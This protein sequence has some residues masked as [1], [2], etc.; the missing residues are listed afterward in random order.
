MRATDNIAEWIKIGSLD[1]LSFV[2]RDVICYSSGCFINFLNIYT[3]EE[4]K[5]AC[6][7]HHL[8]GD[9]VRIVRGHRSLYTFAYAEN[10]GDAAIYVKNYPGFEA[11]AKFT[12]D[13]PP[14]GYS[15]MSFSESSIL[16]TVGDIPDFTISVYNWRTN[17]KL[18][19]FKN[20]LTLENQIVRCNWTKPI[21][22]TQLMAVI[23]TKKVKMPNKKD[24]KPFS[25]LV[26]T[27]EGGMFVVD[28]KG[29]V[30]MLNDEVSLDVVIEEDLE[31]DIIPSLCNYKGGIVVNGPNNEIR[32]Y[33]KAGEWVC[34]WTIPL[35]VSIKNMYGNRAEY[36]IGITNNDKI[37][38]IS[39]TNNEITYLKESESNFNDICLIY[40]TGEHVVALRGNKDL[41]VYETATG[42]MVSNLQLKGKALAIAE[43]PEFPYV[44]VGYSNG[45]LELI[46]A[47]K[48]A[49]L[50]L[51]ASFNLTSNPIS[52]L[53][54]F[55]QGRV[56]VTGYLDVGEFFLIEGLPGTEMKVIT[57]IYANK[58]IVDYML[59]ASKHCYRLFLLPVTTKYMAS[60]KIIRYC[61][62]DTGNIN[63]KEYTMEDDN[64][65]YY[66][67]IPLTDSNRDRNFYMLPYKARSIHVLETKRG[68]PLARLVQEIK[69]GHLL[70]RFNFRMTKLHALTWG[71]DGFIIA[72]DSKFEQN[73]GMAIAHH[74]YQGG[75]KKAYVD[76]L[77]KYIVSLGVEG[78]MVCTSIVANKIDEGLKNKLYELKDSVKYAVMFKRPTIGFKPEKRFHGKTWL[79]VQRALN[80]EKEEEIC[81]EEKDD[82]KKE[83]K[84]IKSILKHLVT[85]NIEG[86]DNERLD[87]LEF[88]LD[89][90]LYNNKRD[91]NKSDCKNAETYLK[92]LI[93]AQDEVS[94]HLMKNYWEPMDIR[95]KKAC[96]IFSKSEIGN[97]VLLPT[98]QEQLRRTVWIAEQRKVE[99][100]LSKDT[101]EPWM[102]V[103][104]E[105]LLEQFQQ[106]PKIE[107]EDYGKLELQQKSIVMERMS[108]I[109]EDT[110]IA[111][112]GTIAQLYIDRSLGH[113]KQ[114]Q[115]VSY[116]QCDI[117]QRITEIDA[118]KLKKYFNAIFE[119]LMNQK[120]REMSLVTERNARLRVIIS[121]MNYFSEKKI[122]MDIIDPEWDD[123]EDPERITKVFDN[124]LTITPYISPSE[125]AILDAKAAEE[126]RI[127]LALLADD[128]RERALM[129][130]MNGVLEV[131]WEDELKKDV[132]I[133][134]CMLEKEPEKYNEEDLRAIRDYEEKVIFLN[135]ERERYKNLLDVEFTKLTTMSRDSIRKFNQKVKDT[136]EIKMHIDSA[137]NQDNLRINRIRWHEFTRCLHH[138]KEHEI[139]EKIVQ[140]E[141]SIRKIPKLMEAL[142]ERTEACRLNLD[143]VDA[144]ERALEKAF[145]KDLHSASPV[146]QEQAAKLYRKRPKTSF[147]QVFSVVLLELARCIVT[148]GSSLILTSDCYDYMKALDQLDQYVGVPPNID[149]PTYN[150]ICKHRRL[151]IEFEIK[152]RAYQFQIYDCDITVATF[153]KRLAKFKENLS[154]LFANLEEARAEYVNLIHNIQTQVVLRRGLVEIP[155]DG[156][157]EN[158]DSAMIILKKEVE[159]INQHIL[160]AGKRKLDVIKKN[161]GFRRNIMAVEWE[162]KRLRMII[163]DLIDQIA[164]IEAVQLTK[165][166]QHYLKCKR[167][168]RKIDAVSFENEVELMA[169]SFENRLKE[170]KEKYANVKKQIQSFKAQNAALDQKITDMN[171]DVCFL[172]I[173][174]DQD[175]D[176]NHKKA[177]Q[178][179]MD[180]LLK[181]NCL[182]QQIQ[183]NHSEILVLQ[184]ELELLRL[185]TYP[186]FKYK[187]LCDT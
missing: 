71:Y 150:L 53:Q 33:K 102:M 93:E 121:E 43:N 122:C 106:V 171:I 4:H 95:G 125:Q 21:Y 26:W 185:K 170:K 129:A 49:K 32:H 116:Y 151:R 119:D 160:A 25:D 123:S 180:I 135:S 2:G 139:R 140:V 90:A 164:D 113:Y 57:T 174:K 186:T 104:K 65:L 126:E 51:M 165:E 42:K 72:R 5:L 176:D 18:G 17:E 37:V 82:I 31:G 158:F 162:H 78:T 115:I 130:M 167:L 47:Y 124:E 84:E 181:R 15:N 110:Q 19:E 11:I 13:G 76:P 28:T 111:L 148:G 153:Q 22:M 146:V 142:N 132:P 143:N 100:F 134:K 59:V 187:L 10:G 182:S 64:A 9:G 34:D 45:V 70:R 147:R 117:E 8:N 29:C 109:S 97:Y 127:R 96:G 58:Q 55:E 20:K 48:P 35:N 184:T 108:Q 138:K 172:N 105:E 60:N 27:P 91:Q 12:L 30:Y 179:R 66:R 128:F 89:T 152:V 7:S 141:G 136:E 44:A 62:I 79:E 88:Y 1:R 145:K 41:T 131:R 63:I 40:P 54:F 166:M 46:S 56:L 159:D 39:N 75:V 157:L 87:M 154:K 99:Q 112:A 77:G 81:K 6:N 156:Q 118:L 73:V 52:S 173:Q 74:R 14:E 92:A 98:N 149:E 101:F 80:I 183:K 107:T 16:V 85:K 50:S 163:N 177:L 69:T 175:L 38:K 155:L 23:A 144:K 3:G 86:P 61:I 161:M 103:P 169:A 67:I 94:N 36:L 133:P 68:D 83:L 168:G 24:L 120:K 137:L 178:T 114:N